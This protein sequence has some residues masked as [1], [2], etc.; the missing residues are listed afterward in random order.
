MRVHMN[1]NLPFSMIMP[2]SLIGLDGI[3]DEYRKARS[4]PKQV[5]SEFMTAEIAKAGGE[6]VVEVDDLVAAVWWQPPPPSDCSADADGEAS[7]VIYV[8]HMMQCGLLAD[9]SKEIAQTV[10]AGAGGSFAQALLLI[11]HD[12][13]NRRICERDA[14]ILVR[15]APMYVSGWLCLGLIQSE[16]GKR[17]E[18][19]ATFEGLLSFESGEWTAWKYLS[20][21]M[22][23]EDPAKAVHAATR[24]VESAVAAGRQVDGHMRVALGMALSAFGSESEARQNFMIACGNPNPKMTPGQWNDWGYRLDG[25]DLAKALADPGS[26]ESKE[27]E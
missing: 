26:F 27:I 2:M 13:H 5:V 4:P 12:G 6:A 22:I 23:R 17:A 3:P 20:M 14:G 21:L 8:S 16:N 18:S 15:C 24:M 11:N 1:L 19:K 10:Y 25:I 9:P 7:Q